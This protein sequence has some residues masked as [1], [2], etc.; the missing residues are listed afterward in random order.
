MT[1]R[2]S[3]ARRDSASSRSPRSTVLALAMLAAF[4]AHLSV[5]VARPQAADATEARPKAVFIVGPTN[6]LTDSNLAD[7]ET[8]ARQAEAA[9]MDVRRVFF[10]HATWDNVLANI[11]GANFV[12]YMGHGYGWPSPYTKT[13]TESRQN[14]MGLNSYDG[15]GKAEYKYYGAIPI[16]DNIR[17]AA[18][19]IVYLNHLCY[20]SGN[21]ESGM[22]I[23]SEDLAR[24][25]VDNFANGWLAAGARAVFAYSWTQKLNHAQALMS[26]DQTI[27]DLFMTPA[28]GS[29]RGFIGWRNKRFASQR[30]PGATNH[31]DPH[32]SYGYYRAVTGDLNMTTAEW[33]AA[34]GS[35]GTPPPPTNSA[36]APQITEL[37]ATGSA[38]ATAANFSANDA[39][40]AFHPNGDGL[41]E[42]LRLT[43]TVSKAAYLDVTV[44]NAAGQTVRSFSVWS[45]EGSAGSRWNGRN[46]SGNWVS[47]GV[48]ELT[49]V[50]RATDGSIGDPV[51]T[52]ALVLTAIK[53]GK[54]SSA[55]IFARDAD[56][57]KQRTKLP[58]A[59]NQ[60]ATVDWTIFDAGGNA[61]R[62]VRSHD[63]LS[64]GKYGF[65]WDG[66]GDNGAW[67]ADG[68]YSSVIEATTSLGSYVQQRDVYVG[69]Y[70]FTPS[71]SSPARGDKLRVAIV[72]TEPLSANPTVR[73]SQPGLAPYTVSTTKVARRKWKFTVTLKSG[74]DA[75]TLELLARGTDKYGGLNEGSFSL[76]LR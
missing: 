61:V 56:S 62:T 40:A 64:A 34:A 37:T 73:I 25:R 16:R 65:R 74:G 12:V 59:L 13:L 55:A 27:D 58:L 76:P 54:P 33:R 36:D 57:L 20:A 50:P 46:N 31:L 42:E 51:S 26:T 29:P 71:T 11:Q 18:N 5:G 70:R 19:A 10:P 17:L 24:E 9:G 4:T 8:M 1:S 39:P 68:W 63:T 14:G 7:A 67:V 32:S 52:Q 69:A 49:Y 60:P 6:G 75:G 28:K 47:D 38:G 43:H 44:A 2:R 23:P 30:T 48:Y 3:I 66:R 41:D 45:P 21:A 35:T 53:V 15:S 72:S 22:A